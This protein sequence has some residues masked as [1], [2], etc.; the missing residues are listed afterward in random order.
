[1]AGVQR[2]YVDALGKRHVA[3]DATIRAIQTAIQRGNSKAARTRETDTVVTTAGSRLQLG[4]AEIRLEDGSNLTIDRLLP[5][6]LPLGY[7][8]FQKRGGRAGRLIVA[9]AVCHL[10]RGLRTWGWVIQLYAARSRRSWGIGD[11]ADLRW[12]GRWARGQGAGLALINPLSAVNSRAHISHRAAD[13]A[14]RST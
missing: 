3:P 13:F 1:M 7:H 4:P 5:A 12:L 8:D 6:D 9:P 2:Y 10:P 14:A 11:L